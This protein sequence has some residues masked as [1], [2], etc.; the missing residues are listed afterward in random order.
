MTTQAGVDL[1][2]MP[3]SIGEIRSLLTT[4]EDRADFAAA[5]E[6]TGLEQLADLLDYWGVH[7]ISLHDP[8]YQEYLRMRREG[9]QITTIPAEEA[10]RLLGYTA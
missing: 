9:Q 4:D 1:S 2:R 10:H 7:A 8:V 5:L 6:S 3:R